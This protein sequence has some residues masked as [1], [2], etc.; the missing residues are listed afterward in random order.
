M[1]DAARIKLA[2][3]RL[4]RAWIFGGLLW[5]VVFLCLSAGIMGILGVDKASYLGTLMLGAAML[6]AGTYAILYFGALLLHIAKRL[7]NREPIM[8]QD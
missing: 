2:R 8:D 4:W 7:W 5:S 1:T 6:A 3:Q